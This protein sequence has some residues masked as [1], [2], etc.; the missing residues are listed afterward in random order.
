ML[1][2]HAIAKASSVYPCIH[3]S[4]THV[5][6]DYTVQDIEM[7]FAVLLCSVVAVP[8]HNSLDRV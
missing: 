7:H 8:A 1:L 3:L 6:Y 2:E 4:V 5:S